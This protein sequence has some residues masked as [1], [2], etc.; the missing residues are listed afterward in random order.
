MT[1]VSEPSE[2][3]VSFITPGASFELALSDAAF[4]EEDERDSKPFRKSFEIVTETV[5]K[6]FWVETTGFVSDEVAPL[7]C[8]GE[9]VP[10]QPANET[11]DMEVANNMAV[12][13]FDN[14]FSINITSFLFYLYIFMSL[15]V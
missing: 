5:S 9:D 6:F 8:A 12:I 11:R 15:S 2:L 1:I 10:L 7:L 13:L 3:W 4:E 14:L